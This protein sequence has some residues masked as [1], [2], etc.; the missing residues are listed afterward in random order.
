MNEPLTTLAKIRALIESW[1]RA[2]SAD[3]RFAATRLLIADL[4]EVEAETQFSDFI[5][6]QLV[7]LRWLV[8]GLY[9][10]DATFVERRSEALELV[11]ALEGEQGFGSFDRS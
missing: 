2:A 11:A 5:H 9:I 7:V 1:E 4:L 6:E 8:T 3:A 10:D